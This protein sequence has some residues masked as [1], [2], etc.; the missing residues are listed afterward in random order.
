[1]MKKITITIGSIVA[2]LIGAWCVMWWGCGVK[3]IAEG[4]IQANLGAD[5][6]TFAEQ[7]NGRL[8]HDWP[9]FELAARKTDGTVKWDAKETA[10]HVRLNNPPYRETNGMPLYVEVIDSPTH[11][12]ETIVNR[13]IWVALEALKRKNEE[14]QQATGPNAQ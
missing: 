14:G 6:A 2:V 10:R 8:P 1:M 13:P 11:A 3:G 12:G 4:D 5:L 9:E 7:H